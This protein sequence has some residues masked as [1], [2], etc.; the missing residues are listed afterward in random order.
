MMLVGG[1][2]WGFEIH[3]QRPWPWK[4][5]TIL[6]G[7]LNIKWI[8]N[9]FLT[10]RSIFI[11]KE[12]PLQKVVDRDRVPSLPAK[13]CCGRWPRLN[14]MRWLKSRIKMTIPPSAHNF[15]WIKFPFWPLALRR[16]FVFKRKWWNQNIVSCRYRSATSPT[17]GKRVDFDRVVSYLWYSDYDRV[18]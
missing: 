14:R 17:R 6:T 9:C 1:L 15:T 16:I 8:W 13:V 2:F 4:G 12:K 18:A 10:S 3:K 7:C 5:S 11:W